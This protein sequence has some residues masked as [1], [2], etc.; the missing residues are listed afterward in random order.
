MDD[1][2]IDPQTPP[3]KKN[4]LRQLIIRMGLGA[5]TISLI[6][7]VIFA[8]IAIF[9]M[10]KWVYPPEEKV[11]FLPGGGGGGG[12]GG[13][14]VHKVQQQQQKRMMSNSAVAKRIASTSSTAAFS[15]PDSS[16]EMMDPGLP[17]EANTAELGSGGGA[18]GGH[19]KGI[20]TGTGAGTGPGKGFGAGQL[21]I[22]A[23]IPTIMKGRCTDVERLKMLHEAGGTPQV[24]EAVKK[25]LEWLKGRQNSDGSWGS[26]Y[27]VAMT[28]LSL[29]CYLG[30]CEGTQSP[31]YGDN[32]TKGMTYLIN[33]ALKHDGRIASNLSENQW[34]YEHAIATYA[35]SES[36]TFSRN[37][38]FKIPELETTVEKAAKIIVD[39]QSKAGGWDYM[40][41]DGDRNDLSVA[42]WQMQALKA[43]HASGVR[44][45]NF[46]KTIRNAVEWIS[47]GAYVDDGKF[48]YTGKQP[49]A[50]MTAVG[51]LCLQ[52]WGKESGSQVRAAVKLIMDGLELR[53]K[54]NGFVKAPDVSPLYAFDYSKPDADPYAWYYAVQVMRNAGGKEWDAMN[55]AILGSI[56]PAQ[57]G[58]GSFQLENGGG[59]LVEVGGSRGAKDSRDVYHQTLNTLMLEVYYRFLPT[60]AGKARSSGFDDLR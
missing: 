5:F 49:R 29:L 30:H 34:V 40:Y 50:A 42:G 44:I 15:L 7:H 36:L 25:S 11:D 46:D 28:G 23:V 35:L 2:Y 6:A 53:E 33:V 10:Y 37:L 59:K 48:A 26:S 16:N 19:G 54:P 58:D 55:K 20:G 4:R 27:P 31:E 18:G 43:A 3:E 21:G 38:Q 13:E 45:D 9:F 39:G 41:K 57:N 32:V 47:K 12:S 8:V 52:Q 14:T 51:S 1:F 56:L 22:G 17:M 60:S 24:E